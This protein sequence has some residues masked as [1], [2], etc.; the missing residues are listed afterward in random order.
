MVTSADTHN[1]G[2]GTGAFSDRAFISSFTGSAGTA[3]VT[4]SRALL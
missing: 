4:L 1:C 2:F 3:A